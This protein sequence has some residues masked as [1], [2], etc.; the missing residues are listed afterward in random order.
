MLLNKPVFRGAS[1]KIPAA[2]IIT[3]VMPLEKYKKAL[4]TIDEGKALKV[5][6]KP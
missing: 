5:V 3:H 6:L 2:K 1:K 4:R